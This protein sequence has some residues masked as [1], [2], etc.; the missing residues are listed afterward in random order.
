MTST[1]HQPSHLIVS[2]DAAEIDTAIWA[3]SVRTARMPLGRR[4]LPVLHYTTLPYCHCHCHCHC[5][6]HHAPCRCALPGL[7]PP[8]PVRRQHEQYKAG[9]ALFTSSSRRLPHRTVADSGYDLLLLH[10]PGNGEERW[11]QTGRWLAMD[12]GSVLPPGLPIF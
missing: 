2:Q 1:T 4:L 7:L 8:F 5:T 12:S 10:S 6:M 9:H 11:R 3:L